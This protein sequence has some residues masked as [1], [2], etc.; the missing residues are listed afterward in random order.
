MH[1]NKHTQ[2]NYT[3]IHISKSVYS[4]RRKV[5]ICLDVD[6]VSND[7]DGAPEAKWLPHLEEGK[8][9]EEKKNGKRMM[10]AS[11]APKINGM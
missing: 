10:I 2:S 7:S 6:V 5:R 1:T 4:P 9:R 11:G 3:K 8:E